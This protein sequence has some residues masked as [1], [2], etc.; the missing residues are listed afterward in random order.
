[1]LLEVVKPQGSSS[2]LPSPMI[3]PASVHA[4]SSPVSF[5]GRKTPQAGW[6]QASSASPKLSGG[7][8][9][10]GSGDLV[11]SPLPNSHGEKGSVHFINML[12]SFIRRWLGAGI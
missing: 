3:W 12:T 4:N 10:L 9:F 5:V 6:R 11:D 7:D 8:V 1:M 2:S